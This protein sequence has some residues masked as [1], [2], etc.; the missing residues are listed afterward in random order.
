M[1][2]LITET[3]ENSIQEIK[4]LVKCGCNL[5]SQNE[6]G[7]T[8]LMMALVNN[9]I[10]VAKILIKAGA[11]VNIQDNNGFTPLMA[12]S[13]IDEDKG[14]DIELV[15]ML[16]EAGADINIKDVNDFSALMHASNHENLKIV[17]I[18][19][20]AGADLDSQNEGGNTAL[21]IAVENNNIKIVKILV[22][23]GADLDYQ[24]EDGDTA[25]MIAV[26]NNNIKIVKMLVEAGANLNNR[27]GLSAIDIM[28][29]NTDR[30][31][32]I[33][34]ST[35]VSKQTLGRKL[36]KE[37]HNLDSI[38]KIPFQNKKLAKKLHDL[39]IKV[40][41]L[42]QLAYNAHK[43][44]GKKNKYL[45]ELINLDELDKKKESHIRARSLSVKTRKKSS[46]KLNSKRNTI[47]G[48][49]SRRK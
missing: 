16:I 25:L 46:S 7:Q 49:K 39:N 6:D 12:A 40:P 5:N 15:R 2:D 24:N 26:E 41:T 20:K 38:E 8:A 27:E 48:K 10:K 37:L 3:T 23:A 29:E 4:N 1:S 44:T 42:K 34:L 13:E 14:D 45:R 21:M 31:I 32:R 9:N 18:L 11:D 30:S 47:G 28:N 35:I 33:F 17:K 22:E 19:I 43:K 36:V